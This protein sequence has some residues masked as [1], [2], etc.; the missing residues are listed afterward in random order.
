MKKDIKAT[1][2]VIFIVIICV[3]AES[4]IELILNNLIK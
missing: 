1:I 3:T 2:A 4:V